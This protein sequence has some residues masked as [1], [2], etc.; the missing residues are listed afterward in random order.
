MVYLR[1]KNRWISV[2]W[3]RRCG[4]YRGGSGIFSYFYSSDS[5]PWTYF[6]FLFSYG[7]GKNGKS[8]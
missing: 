4:K 7:K 1:S 6:Y 3:S 5:G 8:V 2:F